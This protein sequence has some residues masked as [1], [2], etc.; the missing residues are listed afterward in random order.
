MTR[1][2]PTLG[3]FAIVGAA[4]YASY[5]LTYTKPAAAVEK[6]LQ[7]YSDVLADRDDEMSNDKRV[8]RDLAEWGAGA[9]G[10]SRET[11]EHRFRT[12]LGELA[13]RAGLSQEKLVV[14]CGSP[15]PARNPA[16]AERVV[17]FGRR[18]MEKTPDWPD[19][20]EVDGDIQGYG[21][22]RAVLSAVALAQS[23]PWISRVTSVSIRPADDQRQVFELRLGVRTAY[24]PDLIDHEPSGDPAITPVGID[25]AAAVE[26]C[27]ATSLFTPPAVA[28][29]PSPTVPDEPRP[30]VPTQ[31]PPPPYGEWTLSGVSESRQGPLAWLVRENG[32]TEFLGVDQ[33]LYG[34][35][36]V[37]VEDDR[38]IFTDGE[39]ESAVLI[40]QSLDR[41][42]PR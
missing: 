15:T 3:C 30:V 28:P 34:L 41:R 26:R 17:E 18:M 24:A 2:L 37:A 16:V 5:W 6:T 25:L 20:Y 7:Q 13:A 23:Q 33:S 40:G 19:W 32:E 8:A 21:T 9:L 42:R 10:A 38:A 27:V 36:L 1:L 11:V 29:P 35:K 22:Y 31:P 12:G 39:R 14:N 4:G